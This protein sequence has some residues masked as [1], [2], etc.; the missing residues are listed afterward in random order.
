MIC[1]NELV[2]MLKRMSNEDLT[3]LASDVFEVVLTANDS[4]EHQIY[5]FIHLF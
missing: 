5:L 3:L 2:A 1:K 4:I